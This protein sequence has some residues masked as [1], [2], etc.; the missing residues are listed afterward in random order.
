MRLVNDKVG[1]VFF[2]LPEGQI[3]SANA[4]VLEDSLNEHF[5]NGE[6]RI[7]LDLSQLDYVSSAGLRVILVLAKKLRSDSGV[8]ALCNIQPR[9]EEVLEISGFLA[10]LTVFETREQA[11]AGLAQLGN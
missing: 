1:T 2:L 8:M 4:S 10:I 6:R 5:N 11:Q 9:V 7:V 3:N